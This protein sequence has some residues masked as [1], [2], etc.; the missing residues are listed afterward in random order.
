MAIT[1]RAAFAANEVENILALGLLYILN[2]AANFS[3]FFRSG[4]FSHSGSHIL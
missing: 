1:R 2:M 4:W 3:I